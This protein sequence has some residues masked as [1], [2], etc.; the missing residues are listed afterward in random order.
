LTIRKKINPTHSALIVFSD[1]DGTLLDHDTYRFEAALPALSLIKEKSIP[2]ILCSSKTRTEMEW[3]RQKLALTDPFIVENGAAIF[4]PGGRLNLKDQ[5]VR[6]ANGFQIVEWGIPYDRLVGS[7]RQIREET[8]LNLIGFSEMSL[9]EVR[10]YTGMG[11]AQAVRARKR[12]YSEPFIVVD[13]EAP[14]ELLEQSVKRQGLN[15]ARGGRFFHLMGDNDKGRAVRF[16]SALY[17]KE[18]PNLVAIGLGDSPNDLPLLENVDIPI[19][20]KKPSGRHEIWRGEKVVYYTVGIGPAGWNEALLTLLKK[21][22]WH[23]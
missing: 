21:E 5:P 3:Y 14:L 18:N 16:L 1:L 12:D 13:Q 2:L 15:L 4:I 22:E 23:E 19:L 9:E 8:G 20:V 6:E 7:L 17:Q 11:K 10:R